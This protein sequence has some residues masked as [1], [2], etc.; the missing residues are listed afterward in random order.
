M[1]LLYIVVAVGL[2]ALIFKWG[3]TSGHELGHTAGRLLEAQDARKVEFYRES[4]SVETDCRGCGQINRI[5]WHRLRNRPV[6]GKC[7]ARLLPKGRVR[8]SIDDPATSREL[9][10]V[11]DDYEKMWESIANAFDRFSTIK[12]TGTPLATPPAK[13][14]N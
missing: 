1:L 14:M 10:A 13:L 8:I 7:K 6:C 9:V 4:G 5:P 12:P 2:G 11:W 3:H